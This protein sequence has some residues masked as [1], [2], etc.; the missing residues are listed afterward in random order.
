MKKMLRSNKGFTL[1]ELLVVIAILGAI[2]GVVVLNIGSFIGKGKCEAYTTEK[3]NVIT[4]C[5]AALYEDKTEADYLDYL[6]T[7]TSYTW[8]PTENC[9]DATTTEPN[10]CE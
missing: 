9:T 4:A 5:V 6:L 2:A 7:E 1:I 3:H 10:P 8:T